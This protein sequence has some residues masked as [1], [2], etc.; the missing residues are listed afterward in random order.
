MKGLL[1]ATL[2]LL[3]FNAQAFESFAAHKQKARSSGR[4]AYLVGMGYHIGKSAKP[5]D[6]TQSTSL[7]VIFPITKLEWQ[8]ME[9]DMP[10]KDANKAKTYIVHAVKL[11]DKSAM[12]LL[13]WWHIRQI[14]GMKSPRTGVALLG[15]AAA[16]GSASAMDMLS[17]AYGR[18][19][20]LGFDPVKNLAWEI[21]AE[22]NGHPSSSIQMTTL[23]L[24]NA[25]T[26]DGKAKAYSMAVAFA[27]KHGLQ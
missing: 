9:K 23:A 1:C 14:H 25:L 4:S 7:R 17:M 3:A 6:F 22:R 2:A 11:G 16:M 26:K 20:A 24:E 18:G 5:M 13:G 27:K 19:G 15:K 10:A 8:G 12:A 21:L